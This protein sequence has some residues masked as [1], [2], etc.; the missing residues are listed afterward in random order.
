MKETLEKTELHLLHESALPELSPATDAEIITYLRYSCQIVEVA[1]KAEYDALILAICEQFNVT[2][3]DEELQAAGDTFRQEHKLLGATETIKWLS[4]QRISIE[5]WS[6]GIRVTL[7]TKKLKELLF[8]SS[9]DHHYINN[10]HH[11]KSVALSQILVR[12]LANALKIV[13]AIKEESASFC[14]LA[15]EHSKGR[16]SKEN[17]GFAGIRFL[18]ELMP[19]IAEVVSQA[20]EG[21][22]I[23]PIQTTLGYHI[24]K[25]EKWF[26]SELSESVRQEILESLFQAWLQAKL[27]PVVHNGKSY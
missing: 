3:S 7:L 16:Q 25:I 17:G 1:A 5:D 24:I 11:F 14:A 8:G 4:A 2:V 12:D 9:V 26:P 27:N 22:L 21:E 15:L 19:Q 20:K 13:H 6:S 23:G 10:R 18:S